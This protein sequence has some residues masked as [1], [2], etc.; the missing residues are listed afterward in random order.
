M[1]CEQV[2]F[3]AVTHSS[4]L[5]PTGPYSGKFLHSYI[6]QQYLPEFGDLNYHLCI[7]RYFDA[8]LAD[9]NGIPVTVKKAVCMHEEDTSTAWKH[10]EY[11][12]ASND[13]RRGRRLVLQFV[14]TVANYDYIFCTVS[15][16][17]TARISTLQTSMQGILRTL[18][19]WKDGI[20]FKVPE[21]L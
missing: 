12:N 1:P 10:V 21:R 15:F 2:C 5:H 19:S 8:V 3:V 4:F 18:I 6:R 7:C 9:K 17:K 13:M 14:A 11:R 16:G 20:G